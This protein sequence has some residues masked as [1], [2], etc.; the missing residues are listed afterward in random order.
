MSFQCIVQSYLQWLQ[1]SDYNPNCDFCQRE[2]SRETCVRLVCYRKKRHYV[3]KMELII[4][5][6]FSDVVHWA[7][8]DKHARQLSSDTAPAGYTCPLCHECLFPA[9]NLLSPVAD[10]LRETLKDV[11]WAR[12]GLGL[13]LLDEKVEK[14]PESMTASIEHPPVGPRPAPE[15]QNRIPGEESFDTPTSRITG[16]TT[17]LK[18]MESDNLMTSPL[19]RETDID[20]NK[21]KRKSGS[22]LL[23]RWWRNNCVLGRRRTTNAQRYLMMMMLLVVVVLTVIAIF[24]YLSKMGDYTDPL[25]EPL[26]NPN[27]RVADE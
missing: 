4:H 15:G 5:I 10:A 12:A 24:S 14:K 6:R 22:E 9:S 20:D 3:M 2:L 19:L 8:L 21:Y 23:L 27:I 11:N 18:I 16:S 26:N 25:L 7:C 13:P 1:D 17:V